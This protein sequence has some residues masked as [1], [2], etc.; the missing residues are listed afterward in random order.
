MVDVVQNIIQHAF[1][2]RVTDRGHDHLK[3]FRK[4]QDDLVEIIFFFDQT[5][6]IRIARKRDIC[7]IVKPVC[8]FLDLQIKVCQEKPYGINRIGSMVKF[9]GKLCQSLR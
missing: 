7:T 5:D 8:L 9:I 2:G 6:D 1:T 4:V 3:L